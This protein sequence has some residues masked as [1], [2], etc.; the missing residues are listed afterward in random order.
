MPPPEPS[1]GP[2]S[3]FATTQWTLV[4]HAGRPDSPDAARALAAL[5]TSYWYPL[6]AFVRRQGKSAH[7][8]QDLTQEFF[9]RLLAK[10][11]FA[12]VSREKG[13]FRSFLLAALKNFLANEWDKVRAQKRGGDARLSRSMRRRRSRVTRSSRPTRFRP[14]RSSSGGGRSRYW[15]ARWNSS[16]R[17]TSKAG[18]GRCSTS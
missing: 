5:C 4:L 18:A 9:A 7:D 16:A 8:A 1:P 2:A 6:Y 3:A 17:N 15:I 13:R 14:T 12:Q 10:N 11:Y